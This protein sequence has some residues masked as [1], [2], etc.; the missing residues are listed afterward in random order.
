MTSKYLRGKED[1]K[2]TLVVQET[3][4]SETELDFTPLEIVTEEEISD[5]LP[6]EI[7]PAAR[8]NF[9]LFRK[10]D[11]R[12]YYSLDEFNRICLVA[13]GNQRRIFQRLIL[14][15]Q[16]R[17]QARRDVEEIKRA[18]LMLDLHERGQLIKSLDCIEGIY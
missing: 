5:N 9:T 16:Q 7:I 2:E 17:A 4:L 3:L 12:E 14:G 6:P 13:G 8:R 15:V 18:R 11:H 10:I 1:S